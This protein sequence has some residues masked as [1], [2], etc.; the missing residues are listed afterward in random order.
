MQQCA[1]AETVGMCALVPCDAS[2]ARKLAD[3]VIQELGMNHVC[4]VANLNSPVQVGLW[5]IIAVID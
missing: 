3:A 2:K 4:D 5:V 1:A